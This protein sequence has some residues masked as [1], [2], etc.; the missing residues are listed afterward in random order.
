MYPEDLSMMVSCMYVYIY[1]YIYVYTYTV[2]AM[3]M[4]HVGAFPP[5]NSTPSRPLETMV[6]EHLGDGS[7]QWNANPYA[8]LANA[9]I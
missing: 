1:I 7:C 6:L 9:G 5:Y 3:Y 2:F 4:Q 8:L